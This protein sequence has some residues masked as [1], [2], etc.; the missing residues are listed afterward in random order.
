MTYVA[1]SSIIININSSVTFFINMYNIIKQFYDFLEQNTSV[2]VG[3]SKFYVRWVNLCCDFLK[4]KPGIPV[5]HNNKE[6]FLSHLAET[7]EE[8]KVRQADYALNLYIYFIS[9]KNSE[10]N[11]NKLDTAAEWI[12]LVDRVRET[13][14]LKHLS[15]RTEETYLKWLR[16]F[17]SFVQHKLPIDLTPEDARDFLSYLAS[18]RKVSASTQ[19]Q[20]F[21]ALLFMFR[22][23]L[24][25]KDFKIEDTVRAKVKQRIPVVCSRGEIDKILKNMRGIPLLMAKLTYGAGLRLMECVRLRIGDVD[26]E[27]GVLTVR[28][29]KGDKDRCTLL[30]ESIKKDLVR[31][32]EFSRGIYED[33]RRHKVAGVMLPNALE[34]KYPKVGTKWEW[35]WLFPSQKLSCDPITK[36]IRR[37]HAHET[38]FQRSFSK[39]VKSAKI[40]KRVTVHT[41]RHSFATHLLE[42]GNDIRT[43]QEL[44][45]HANLQTTMIYTHVAKKNILGVKSPLDG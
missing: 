33:D 45:G 25:K 21:N 1:K 3:S 31:Q 7:Q 18:E 19:N 14:R 15:M 43:I 35:Q 42:K 37:H 27:R 16:D 8:H 32:I 40:P 20:A 24:R 44:L 9:H 39:A 23:G 41:L 26:L 2:S 4:I 6:R 5:Q 13:M 17:Y 22:H 38:Q 30:P 36:K 29:G 28:G 12:I 11:K 34:R 10:Q